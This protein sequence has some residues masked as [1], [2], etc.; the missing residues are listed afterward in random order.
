MAYNYITNRDSPNYTPSSQSR[1]VFGYD[2][3]IEG[4][5][6]HWWG[7][8]AQNPQFDNIVSYLCRSGGNT[9]AHYVATG[10]DRKVAC[11]VDPGNV[12]WHT[13]SAWGNSR[14]I[15]IELDPRA[16]PEDYDVAAELI[17]DIR[18]AYGDVDLYWHSYFV[19]TAC[20]GV[21]DINKLD[22]LS[23]TKYS[24]DVE[25][26]QGGNKNQPSQPD[27]TPQPEPAKQLYRLIVDGKQVAAY[28][29]D[30]NAFK[31][32]NQYGATGII[33]FEGSDVTAAILDKFTEKSPTTQNPDGS[34]KPD[35]GN[36]ITDKDDYGDIIKENNGILKTIL[37]ILTQLSSAFFSIFKSKD[38]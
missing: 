24:H 11:I 30:S 31:G 36:P 23:Y 6:I 4:I 26:G 19:N 38:K 17:A 20:P 16:R 1:A 12:A 25:W 29:T 13:G 15:G 2:R 21:Y 9:S 14:T 27:P 7:D 18:S 33:M 32:Y 5:T 34:E 8:P 3:I 28:S 22:Q 35:S 10:T 37:D